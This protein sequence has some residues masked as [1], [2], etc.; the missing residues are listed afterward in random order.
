LRGEA[1]DRL[2]GRSTGDNAEL[3]ADASRESAG[4][5]FFIDAGPQDRQATAEL[6]KLLEDMGLRAFDPAERGEGTAGDAA[7]TAL[8]YSRA[9]LV[10]FGRASHT[11]WREQL[12]ARARRLEGVQIIPVLLPGGQ[13]S[14]LRSYG[15]D[16][17]QTIDLTPGPTAVR[18][19]VSSLG[20]LLLTHS[21]RS[22]RTADAEEPHP[23]PGAQ[24]YT[25]DN[26]R[27]FAGREIEVERLREAFFT[28]DVV[29]VSGPAQV[30]K[31][32]LLKAGLLPQL[33]QVSL[34]ESA[35]GQ[36]G[37]VAWLDYG[38]D[39][40]PT[41]PAWMQALTGS[42]QAAAESAHAPHLVVID[43][44]DTFSTNGSEAAIQERAGLIVSAIRQAG[45]AYK[46]I[47]VWRDA[48]VE[49]H[50]QA[51]LDAGS[52][53]KVSHVAVDPLI[54]DALRRAIEQP[55]LRAG[56]LLEPG[57]AERLMESAGNARNAIVQLQLALAAIWPRRQRGWITN[58]HLDDA[59]HLGGVFQQHIATVLGTL[60]ED[61]RRA[62]EAIFKSLVMLDTTLK[63]VPLSQFW[64]AVASIPRL[65]HVDALALRDRLAGAGLIDLARATAGER[66][67]GRGVDT[68][69]Q[70]ALV[71]PNAMAYFGGGDVVPDVRFLM[72]RRSQ[73]AA[74][75]ERWQRGK[76]TNDLLL[77]GSRLSEAEGWL[78][79]R[80]DELSESERNFIE[81]SLALR[82]RQESPE[83]DDPLQKSL[84]DRGQEALRNTTHS[85]LM[86]QVDEAM[87]RGD[88]ASAKALLRAAYAL[89]QKEAPDRPP[90]AYLVQRLA[91]ATYKSRQPSE[92]AALR[93]A[94][95]LLAT[96]EPHTSNDP[97]TLGLWAAVHKRLWN[98]TEDQASLDSS[99]RA[100]DRGFYLRND[101]Y[102]GINLAFVLNVR[103]GRSSD[104]AEAVTD[105]IL[106]ERV[107]R[108][109]LSVCEAWIAAH[110]AEGDT[111]SHERYWVS[112]TI[113]EAMV[114]LGDERA[115]RWL[116]ALYASAPSAWMAD[117]TKE[118]IGKLQALLADSPLK[119]LSATT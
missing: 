77:N 41:W 109:V 69:V 7:T 111:N 91:L 23:Y 18:D 63:L 59:G 85:L 108:E 32:S 84:Q 114:G 51:L 52:G 75:V 82:D 107:R 99:V 76:Q 102:N 94:L 17:T 62:V 19:T 37:N 4:F 113:G 64:S 14:A 27:F 67:D 42:Q 21:R 56:H 68:D 46:V 35:G 81:A 49:P 106:A 48:L 80:S 79:L 6:R 10:C 93:E 70:L 39:A 83:I 24:P 57:L 54:G 87:N 88:F 72:W 97:E 92:L 115:Q 44:A 100:Y 26:A 45:S 116:D 119:H 36:L 89:A 95:A 30:G 50:R 40:N 25:E 15:L 112:A 118:Q 55:A 71:R 65:R 9:L 28:S 74:D 8:D 60:A 11:A 1:L 86:T 105:F 104:A 101:Y 96:L 90:D 16:E 43:A 38:A 3:V 73:F 53:L 13:R 20:T 2:L 61:E 22:A 12:V 66:A 103:A 117:S 34:G 29:F 33:R 78:E 98:L 110:R 31:T 5:D 47:V 58:K